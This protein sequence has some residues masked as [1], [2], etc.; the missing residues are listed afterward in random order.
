MTELPKP[1]L[2]KSTEI[3]LVPS[4]FLVAALGTADTNLHRAA[5]SALG[6]VI[7]GMWW[8]CIRDALAEL[9]RE[10]PEL[11]KGHLPRRTRMFALLPLVFSV[12]WALSTIIHLALWNTPLA[13]K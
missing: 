1:D 11:Q 10:N 9:F 12:G 6:L 4:S 3:F 8:Y 2:I 13:S 5:V 7:S